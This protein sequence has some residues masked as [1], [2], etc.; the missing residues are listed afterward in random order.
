[1]TEVGIGVSGRFG[2]RD[3][4]MAKEGGGNEVEMLI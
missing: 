4:D 1:M 3:G 2:G